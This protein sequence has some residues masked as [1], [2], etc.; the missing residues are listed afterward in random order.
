MAK[1][2]EQAILAQQAKVN[3]ATGVISSSGTVPVPPNHNHGEVS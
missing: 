1:E 2:E 3:T